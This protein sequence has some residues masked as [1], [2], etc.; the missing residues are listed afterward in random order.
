M[1]LRYESS[2]GVLR[3]VQWNMRESA[4]VLRLALNDFVQDIRSR[5]ACPPAAV[6]EGGRRNPRRVILASAIAGCLFFGGYAVGQITLSGHAPTPTRNVS[7][8]EDARFAP[9]GLAPSAWAFQLALPQENP[10]APLPGQAAIPQPAKT[11]MKDTRPLTGDEIREAQAWLQAFGFYFGPIDG[12]PGP[13]TT[14]AV[15]RYRGA[16]QMEETD[17]LDRSVLQQVRQQGGQ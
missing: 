10:L 4:L 12:L 3:L 9:E 7:L 13:Q 17:I 11:T 8:S 16:R 14:A 5:E 1:G 2:M 15:K 6:L